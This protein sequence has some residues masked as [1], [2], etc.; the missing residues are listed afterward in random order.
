MIVQLVHRSSL[1]HKPSF[2]IF[3]ASSLLHVNL[4]ETVITPTFRPQQP[5]ST[6]ERAPRWSPTRLCV[7]QINDQDEPVSAINGL[8]LGDEILSWFSVFFKFVL[9]ELVDQPSSILV[10][11]FDP[12]FNKLIIAYV[13]LLFLLYFN[14]F[15]TNSWDSHEYK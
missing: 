11:L 8:D 15:T 3:K 10:V 2:N 5:K 7:L 13:H 1:R 14:Y 9:T 6:N 4:E 12:V